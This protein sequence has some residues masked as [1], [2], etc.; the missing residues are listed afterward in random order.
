MQELL[1]NDLI[2]ISVSL[3]ALFLLVLGIAQA[4]GMG[5]KTTYEEKGRD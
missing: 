1:G 5:L 2:V 3:F 4:L